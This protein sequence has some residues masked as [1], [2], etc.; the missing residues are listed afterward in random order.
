MELAQQ[1]LLEHPNGNKII[2][3]P[4]GTYLI[5]ATLRWPGGEA[6]VPL[7]AEVLDVPRRRAAARVGPFLDVAPY[8]RAAI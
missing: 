5:S 3:L 1:A 2:Y 8:S 7:E 6:S 4:N